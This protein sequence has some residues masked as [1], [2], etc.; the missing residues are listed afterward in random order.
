[1]A[2]KK[3]KSKEEEALEKYQKIK[4]VRKTFQEDKGSDLARRMLANYEGKTYGDY[5]SFEETGISDII[6]ANENIATRKVSEEVSYQWLI[7]NKDVDEL[8]QLIPQLPK[9][10]DKDNLTY[11]WIFQ[12][13]PDDGLTIVQLVPKLKDRDNYSELFNLLEELQEVKLNK[14]N[15]VKRKKIVIK[16]YDNKLKELKEN[17]KIGEKELGGELELQ[18]AYMYASIANDATSLAAIEGIEKYKHEQLESEYKK[19]INKK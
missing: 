16:F 2:D 19:A 12:N 7:K 9:L 5:N 14:E 11:K 17:K 18:L 4:Q 10:G 15:P 6:R 3:E 1:M 13:K 8:V